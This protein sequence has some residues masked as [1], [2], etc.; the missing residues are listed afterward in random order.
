[1]WVPSQ[2]SGVIRPGGK[3]LYVLSHPI[4]LSMCPQCFA[5]QTIQCR[6]S[7]F[8]EIL[9]SYLTLKVWGGWS[10]YIT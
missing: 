1:M 2:N 9:N 10:Q 3:H 5:F 7:V 6:L 4:S 8:S